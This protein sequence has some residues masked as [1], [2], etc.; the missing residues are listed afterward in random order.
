MQKFHFFSDPAHGWIKVSKTLLK[1]LGIADKIT[2]YSYQKN[3]Y[4]YLEE[5]CDATTF[6]EAM[7]KRFGEIQF[8]Y[9]YC[10]GE[11]KIRRFQTYK[12]D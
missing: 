1:E 4:A 10:N 2:K 8:V 6:C 12:N 5:D 11:S 7:K 9:H 3:N